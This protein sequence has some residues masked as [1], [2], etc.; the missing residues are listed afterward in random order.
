MPSRVVLYFDFFFARDGARGRISFNCRVACDRLIFM[1]FK[2]LRSLLRGCSLRMHHR[3]FAARSTKKSIRILI[4]IFSNEM[5]PLLCQPRASKTGE[6]MLSSNFCV[7]SALPY[8]KYEP[9]LFSVF[10]LNKSVVVGL[11]LKARPRSAKTGFSLV[12]DFC[13]SYASS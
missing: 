9:S 4:F 12:S 8:R 10:S 3:S 1:L 13:C 6:E 11:L 7:K 2:R 5:F